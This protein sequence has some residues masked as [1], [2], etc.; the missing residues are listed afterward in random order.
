MLRQT[1]YADHYFPDW[2]EEQHKHNREHNRAFPI[3][4]LTFSTP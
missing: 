1:F 2:T 4:N 3:S